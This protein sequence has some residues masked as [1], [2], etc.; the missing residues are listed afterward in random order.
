MIDLTGW[1]EQ[2]I[3]KHGVEVTVA[4]AD[5]SF[6]RYFRV[7]SGDESYIVMDAPPAKED[8]G[9]YVHAA[10]RLLEIGL[11][12]P[13]ILAADDARGFLL[14]T[15]LGTQTYLEQLTPRTVERLY[16]D[17]LGALIVLQTG[18][19]KDPKGFP[20]YDDALLMQEMELFRR[21]Y[22]GRHLQ[23]Q[24]TA[25][26]HRNLDAMFALLLDNARAQGKVWVH[27]DYHSRNLMVTAANNPGILDFQDAVIGPVTYDL[28]SL[29]R[30][31][32]I[33]WPPERVEEWAK[34]Y[35]HL[36]RQS[37]LPV[38]EDDQR[39]MR[40]FD[41]MGVQRHLKVL[42]IFSRLAYRDG[43]LHFL[44]DLPQVYSYLTEVC[45][46][47]PEL[48]PLHALLMQFPPPER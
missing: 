46:V 34:G 45:A 4:S 27:R 30:D 41:W 32:Y 23:Q 35:H 37:G 17:A 19:Y 40:N 29:L 25:G 20:D 21:W 28:V 48:T 38:H 36:A 16:G 1:V 11:N 14:L 2:R 10:N 24:L 39:F 22:V 7:E 42:G 5:A 3:G 12:V 47:Y 26:Q 31:C 18:I 44:D 9:P 33:S 43:K 6:R 8:V 15:D 13:E